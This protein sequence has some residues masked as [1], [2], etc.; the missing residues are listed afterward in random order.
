M[1]IDGAGTPLAAGMFDL[2]LYGG[3]VIVAILALGVILVAMRRRLG[4]QQP[5]GADDFSVEQVEKARSIYTEHLDPSDVD[6]PSAFYS[7]PVGGAS[8]AGVGGAVDSVNSTVQTAGIFT[9]YCWGDGDSLVD[10]I[11][12]FSVFHN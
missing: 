2:A 8:G 7:V 6:A 4:G 10:G 3:I 12:A 1:V 11:T 9:I 5:Q